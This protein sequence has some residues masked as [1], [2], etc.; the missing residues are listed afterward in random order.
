MHQHR[1]RIG[2]I[3]FRKHRANPGSQILGGKGSG[4]IRRIHM[5]AGGPGGGGAHHGLVLLV[6]EHSHGEGHGTSSLFAQQIGKR[7]GQG[8]RALG[9]MAA[10]DD[11]KRRDVHH[12]E[13]AGPAGRFDA[14][15]LGLGGNIPPAFAQH[16]HR[17]QGERRV[18]GL[19]AAEQACLESAAPIGESPT[20]RHGRGALARFARSIA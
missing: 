2:T 7:C 8:L 3:F 16:A 14:G 13:A 5:K 11:G 10:V 15:R 9:V 12:L 4:V 20:K 6:G 19:V 18:G 1:H 17:L